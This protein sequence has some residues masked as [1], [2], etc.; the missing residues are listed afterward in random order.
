MAPGGEG[1]PI[2]IASRAHTNSF[3]T[4][5]FAPIELTLRIPSILHGRAPLTPSSGC[6]DISA[7]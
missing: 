2:N 4:R 6:P 5:Y 3:A 7:A 1:N